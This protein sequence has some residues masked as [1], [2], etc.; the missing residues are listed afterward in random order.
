MM[1]LP[2][3]NYCSVQI[4]SLNC[5]KLNIVN[6]FVIIFFFIRSNNERI[7]F[8]NAIPTDKLTTLS[9]EKLCMR[10]KNFTMDESEPIG[11]IQGCPEK[12]NDSMKMEEGNQ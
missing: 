10:L 4:I 9:Y 8:P 6:I 7:G 3:K 1:N 12:E 2:G 11:E 5:K